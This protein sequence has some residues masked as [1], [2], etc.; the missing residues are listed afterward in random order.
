[1]AQIDIRYFVAIAVSA[2]LTVGAIVG[3]NYAVDPYDRFGNNRIGHYLEDDRSAKV[4]QI[5]AYP[6]DSLLLGSSKVGFIDPVSVSQQ[7][8]FYNA[9]FLGVMPEEL[10]SFLRHHGARED[11][12]VIGLDL[13][14][15]NL[16]FTPMIRADRFAELAVDQGIA[17]LASIDTL[18]ASLDTLMRR[19]SG[20]PVGLERNGQRNP[21]R[22]QQADAPFTAPTH[23]KMIG[24]LRSKHY[25]DFVYAEE[26]VAVLRQMRALLL[27]R[28]QAHI[29]F[30]NPMNR[31]ELA[32]L[33]EIPAGAGLE[34][35]RRDMK[36]VF[37]Q[38]VDLS[39]G[40]WSGDA[41]YFNSDPFHY[42]P[43]T[44]VDFMRQLLAQCPAD[45]AP[46]GWRGC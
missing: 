46:P 21:W 33:K 20:E 5:Q 25:A 38:A 18:N 32:L 23:A 14:M 28:R 16:S 6:H 34:R 15:F 1:M 40:P 43:E 7:R 35:L 27:E 39:D 26:R 3:T 37:P 13:F 10:L 36:A 30:L 17:Y 11:L 8:R 19:L 2:A 45:G 41:A 12:V 31:S 9:G 42:R 29:V 22:I 44:G 24:E 4:K